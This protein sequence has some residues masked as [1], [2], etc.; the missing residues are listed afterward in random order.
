MVT[1]TG[2]DGGGLS[3][4]AS[5]AAA[6]VAREGDRGRAWLRALPSAIS[7]AC[8]AWGLTV[9]G[10]P[11]HGVCAV[12]LPVLSGRGARMALKASWVDQETRP[13]PVALTAW[14]GEGAVRLRAHRVTDTDPPTLLLLTDQLDPDRDL[15]GVTDDTEATAVLGAV[16]ARLHVPAPP[17]LPTLADRTARW[18]EAVPVR[19]ARLGAPVPPRAF[20][21]ARETLAARRPDAERT[22]LHG[23]L[24]YANVLAGAD[25]GWHAIDPKGLAGNPAYDTTPALWNRWD[26]L[27]ATGDVPRAVRRRLDVLCDAAGVDREA[28]ARWSVVRT[29]VNLLDV[30]GPAGG[31][32]DFAAR[33]RTVAET[34]AAR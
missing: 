24:H 20:A 30:S 27:V 21:Q 32:A 18:A 34:L 31:D 28:A 17:G 29:L 22:L 7:G 33:Q 4:P 8:D 2:R 12:V 5:F 11:R 3:I 13:E 15:T 23:D 16:L 9:D 25:G 19:Q 14:G 6:T 10:A 1:A 26:D